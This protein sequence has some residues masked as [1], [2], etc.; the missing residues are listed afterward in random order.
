MCRHKYLASLRRNSK[1]IL[2]L[3]RHSRHRLKQNLMLR[4]IKNKMHL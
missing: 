1:L 4:I 2:I 3:R